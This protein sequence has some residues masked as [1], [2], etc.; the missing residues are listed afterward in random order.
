MKNSEKIYF[1]AGQN[2][3]GKAPEAKDHRSSQS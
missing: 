2:D 1:P 3:W